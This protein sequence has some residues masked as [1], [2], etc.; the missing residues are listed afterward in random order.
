MLKPKVRDMVAKAI[1]ENDLFEIFVRKTNPNKI[2]IPYGMSFQSVVHMAPKY[3]VNIKIPA[4]VKMLLLL[5]PLPKML[6]R[7]INRYAQRA[8]WIAETETRLLD[9]RLKNQIK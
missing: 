2:N 3:G 1:Y 7:L 9:P 4:I 5:R 6:M 8:N